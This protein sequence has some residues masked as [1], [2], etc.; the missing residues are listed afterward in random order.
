M[1]YIH[2]KR[3]NKCVSGTFENN[4]FILSL[5][6]DDEFS[7]LHTFGYHRVP[8]IG[9][10]LMLCSCAHSR[11]SLGVYGEDYYL[12]LP[13]VLLSFPGTPRYALWL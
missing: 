11:D 9:N 4:A 12:C 5:K 8:L 7:T 13:L 3:K 10:V 1:E 2:A 6:D